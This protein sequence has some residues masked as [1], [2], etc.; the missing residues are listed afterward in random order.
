MLQYSPQR[1]QTWRAALEKALGPRAADYTKLHSKQLVGVLILVYARTD[2]AHHVSAVS[3]SSVALGPMG[4]F[5]KGAVAVRLKYNDSVLCFVN[6]HLAA[7]ANQVDARN[8]D[9]ADVGR[10][11]AFPPEGGKREAWTPDLR[12]EVERV[13]GS[14]GIYDA[15]ALFWV[16][17]A[18]Y[19]IELPRADVLRM[20]EQDDLKM[21]Q[22]FDQLRIQRE[23]GLAFQEFEEAPI[24]FPP[25][26]KFDVG[27]STYDTSEKQRVPSWTDRIQWLAIRPE[28]VQ[29]STY[30]AHFGVTL[31]DH[32]PISSFVRAE[33][34]TVIAAKRLEVLHEVQAELDAHEND[35]A[36]DVQLRPG[37]AVEFDVVNYL[38]PQTREIEVC[39]VGEVVA[40]WSFV[41]KPGAVGIAA[42]WLTVSPASGLIL[43]GGSTKVSLTILVDDAAAAELNF[44]G[45]DAVSDLLVVSVEKKDLFLSVSAREYRPTCFGNS[46]AKLNRLAGVPIRKASAQEL[47]DIVA[48]SDTDEIGMEGAEEKTKVPKEVK[49]LIGFLVEHG[50]ERDDLFLVQGSNALVRVVRECLDTGD[51]FPLDK[52]L[53]HLSPSATWSKTPP[54]LDSDPDRDLYASTLAAQLAL[55]SPEM[56]DFPESSD[57]GAL[58]LSPPHS[59]TEPTPPTSLPPPIPATHPTDNELTDGAGTAAV[60]DC[61]L[62]LLDSL[63]PPVVGGPAYSRALRVDARDDAYQ[64][65][66]GLPAQHASVLLYLLAFLRVLVNTVQDP[67]AR[68][69]RID[70]LAVVF[71]A[72]LVKPGAGATVEGLPVAARPQRAKKFVALLLAAEDA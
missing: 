57:I 44:T 32:K 2:C 64:L 38:E 35:S 11:M 43:P 55:A 46:L 49:R 3:S 27:T 29:S 40:Q 25:T 67:I 65:V 1:E 15:H 41:I 4:F 19:R 54:A 51:E 68:E 48:M 39:N 36:P 18:N 26:F 7:F 10:Y 60:A 71:S 59:A 72:V 66:H 9:F 58:S 47:E 62:R 33:V 12:P 14:Y 50:L 16:A 56:P 63:D 52:L 8:R 61:L 45:P 37:P 24:T 70:R 42:R 28:A 21:L 5:N 6:A 34:L 69:G 30:A 31:S 22:R 20:I 23:N 13:A 17:D 53:P